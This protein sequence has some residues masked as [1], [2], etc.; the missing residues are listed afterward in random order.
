MLNMNKA[1]S[2]TFLAGG[3]LL[4]IFGL[5]VYDSN[6][7]DIFRIV[8][9]SANIKSIWLSVSGIVVTIVGMVGLLR[10]SKVS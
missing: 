9:G 6:S 2:L 1:L 3:I 5:I 8:T 7:S 10:R 4:I